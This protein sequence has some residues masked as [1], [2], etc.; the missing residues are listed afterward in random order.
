MLKLLITLI[1]VPCHPV[2]FCYSCA[3]FSF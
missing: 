2:Y 3:N 1:V